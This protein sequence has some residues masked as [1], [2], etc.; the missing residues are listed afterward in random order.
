MV[1]EA[2]SIQTQNAVSV[3]KEKFLNI[4]SKRR[5]TNINSEYI[6]IIYTKSKM[7]SFCNKHA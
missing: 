7:T 4:V 5:L 2:I 3:F 6:Y 1:I